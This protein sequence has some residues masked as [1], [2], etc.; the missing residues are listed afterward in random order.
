MYCYI[1]Q[2]ANVHRVNVR[3]TEPNLI[4][5]PLV[6]L[7][8]LY[9]DDFTEIMIISGFSQWIYRTL[10]NYVY[11]IDNFL[12]DLNCEGKILIDLKCGGKILVDLNCE[13]KFWLTLFVVEKS[14][15]VNNSYWS[16]GW[17]FMIS[18]LWRKSYNQNG[19]NLYVFYYDRNN[20]YSMFH[21]QM[22]RWLILED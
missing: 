7:T 12:V 4:F 18:I 6:A 1:R 3:G 11:F 15:E 19:L 2:E 5:Q 17:Y 20:S 22:R 21:H 8:T 16:C 13:D 14:N 9:K 10:S